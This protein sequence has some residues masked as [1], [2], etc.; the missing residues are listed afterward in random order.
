MITIEFLGIFR[1][2]TGCEG[3]QVDAGEFFDLRSLCKYLCNTYPLLEQYL[4][5]TDNQQESNETHFNEILFLK[6]GSICKLTD[7]LADGDGI[8]V[9]I[10]C[11][12]G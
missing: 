3:I 7:T 1:D 4:V 6:N 5:K 2:F 8:V 9:T 12:G 11:L 10:S